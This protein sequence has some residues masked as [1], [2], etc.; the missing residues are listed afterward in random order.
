MPHCQNYSKIPQ[1]LN[2]SKIPHRQNYSKIL[3]CRNYS[4]TKYYNRRKDKSTL[5]N[6][7]IHDFSVYWLGSYTPTKSGG[8]ELDL[9]TQTSLSELVWSCKCFPHLGKMP[10]STYNR[11]SRAIIMKQIEEIR[12]HGQNN[13]LIY[14][15]AVEFSHVI[16]DEVRW[17]LPRRN[18]WRYQ[19]VIRKRESKIKQCNGQNFHDTKE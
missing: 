3:H 12:C 13:Q 10:T 16:Y 11:A 19:R 6:K 8:V 9:W 17:H 18:V 2:F 4:K 5:P 14:S 15:A 7:K 1:C